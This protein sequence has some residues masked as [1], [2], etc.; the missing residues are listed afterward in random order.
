MMIQVGLLVCAAFAAHACLDAGHVLCVLF[1]RTMT[2]ALGEPWTDTLGSL[3]ASTL[4]YDDDRSNPVLR[5]F[6]AYWVASMSLAR[7]LALCLMARA[8]AV[9][10]FVAMAYF[11]EALVFEFEGTVGGTVGQTRA[12]IVALTSAA[13]GA[14]A[15]W[16]A[17]F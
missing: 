2:R 5:R 14:G 9:L 13:L 8:P 11:L 10:G 12:R 1:P 6:L 3:Y 15:L 4:T 17:H 16:L 7:A